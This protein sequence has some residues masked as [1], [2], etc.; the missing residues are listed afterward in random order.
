MNDGMTVGVDGAV[1]RVYDEDTGPDELLATQVLGP[2]GRLDVT[3]TWDPC[4]GC[5]GTPDL[6]VEFELENAEVDVHDDTLFENDHRFETGI[7]N[8]FG[9]TLLDVG[10]QLP[11]D[12]SLMPACHIMTN[13][14]R[15]WRF[16]ATNGRDTPSGLSV[17]GQRR[18]RRLLRWRPGRGLHRLDTTVEREHDHPR[19]RPPFC[20]QLRRHHDS[21]LLQRFCDSPTCGHCLW[22]QETDHDASMRGLRTITRTS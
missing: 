7:W 19:V 3:F 18:L 6:Y 2:D 11:G 15:A 13:A 22:C 10:A 17:A 16:T 4:F 14:I 1:A 12:P 9:G 5:D 20:E 8:D 21:G